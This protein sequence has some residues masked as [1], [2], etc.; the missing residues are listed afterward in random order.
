MFLFS[1]LCE[2]ELKPMAL[3]FTSSVVR[4]GP[5]SR[6]QREQRQAGGIGV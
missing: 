1:I 5:Q 2:L 6:E 4:A 3:D